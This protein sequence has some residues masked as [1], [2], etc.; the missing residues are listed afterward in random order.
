MCDFER[1]GWLDVVAGDAAADGI[2]VGWS[3]GTYI[4]AP[5]TALFLGAD[6]YAIGTGDIDG[7]GDDD[8]ITAGGLEYAVGSFCND[9]NGG[10]HGGSYGVSADARDLVIAD[11]DGDGRRDIA[12]AGG[13]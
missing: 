10:F 11:L 13:V 8:V 9:G 4:F 2:K 7:D 1:D 5:P 3:L 12:F 6:S